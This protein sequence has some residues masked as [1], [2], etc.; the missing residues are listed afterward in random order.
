[1]AVAMYSAAI[2]L[3]SSSESLFALR[4]KVYLERGLYAEAL[5]DAEKVRVISTIV[6]AL[7]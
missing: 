1:M 5:D 4:S 7:C 6:L 3:D 2:K